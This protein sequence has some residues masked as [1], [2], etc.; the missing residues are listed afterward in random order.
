MPIWPIYHA[1]TPRREPPPG[2]CLNYLELIIC[3]T[4]RTQPGRLFGL[5][6]GA[7]LFTPPLLDASGTDAVHREIT[8]SSELYSKVY[9]EVEMVGGKD[10]ARVAQGAGKVAKAFLKA[11]GPVVA[12]QAQRLQEHGGGLASSLKNVGT[13]PCTRARTHI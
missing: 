4:G 13:Q 10:F 11:E 8:Q 7:L 9:T 12:R 5:V 1:S 2:A 6:R 3:N